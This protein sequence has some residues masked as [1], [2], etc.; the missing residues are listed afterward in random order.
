MK[1]TKEEVLKVAGLARLH[2]DEGAI[3]KF[4]GQIG[5]ILEYVDTLEQVDA[6]DVQ[7]A[8][9]AIPLSNAFREDLPGE[10]MD[11]DN[12]L[13]NAPEKEDGSFVVPKI[14]G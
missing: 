4:A 9:H 14:I 2:M 6:K 11:R 13:S 5:N 10:H 1:I 7:P 8:T 12:A 3:D